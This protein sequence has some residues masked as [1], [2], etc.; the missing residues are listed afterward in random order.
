MS[1]GYCGDGVV[2]GRGL[3][4]CDS[5]GDPCCAL[6]CTF[7]QEGTLCASAPTPYCL[8]STCTGSNHSCPAPVCTGFC[9][10]FLTNG[11]EVCDYGPTGSANCTAFCAISSC[12]DGHINGGS[13]ETCE[14][15]EAGVDTALCNAIDCTASACGDGILNLAAGEVCDASTPGCSQCQCRPGFAP[16]MLCVECDAGFFA[17]ASA[18]C[19]ACPTP[20]RCLGGARCT[21]STTGEL[22]ASCAAGFFER[23]GEC[24]SC[25]DIPWMLVAQVAAV[26][27]AAYAGISLSQLLSSSMAARL[28]FMVNLIQL[29]SI[30]VMVPEFNWPAWFLNSVAR[31]FALLLRLEGSA[32]CLTPAWVTW[33]VETV[34]VFA[35]LFVGVAAAL[36]LLRVNSMRVARAKNVPSVLLEVLMRRMKRSAAARKNLLLVVGLVFMPLTRRAMASFGCVETPS[37]RYLAA[38]VDVVCMSSMHVAAM[39]ASAAV[40]L[41]VSVGVPFFI[42]IGTLSLKRNGRLDSSFNTYGSLYDVYKDKH[43]YFEGVIFVRRLATTLAAALISQGFMVGLA[44]AGVLLAYLA[45]VLFVRPYRAY[46]SKVFGVRVR[47]LYTVIDILTMTVAMLWNALGAFSVLVADGGDTAVF[48]LAVLG[49]IILTLAALLAASSTSVSD[50]LAWVARNLRTS[51]RKNADPLSRI[52]A[53]MEGCFVKGGGGRTFEEGELV[54]GPRLRGSMNW[55]LAKYYRV[56]LNRLRGVRLSQCEAKMA[57]IKMKTRMDGAEELE[58]IMSALVPP[59][60]MTKSEVRRRVVKILDEVFVDGSGSGAKAAKLLGRGGASTVSK[61]AEQGDAAESKET[62]SR[63]LIYLDGKARR[64]RQLRAEIIETESFTGL[65][66]LAQLDSSIEALESARLSVDPSKRLSEFEKAIAEAFKSLARE[67]DELDKAIGQVASRRSGKAPGAIDADNVDSC[68]ALRHSEVKREL[69]LYAAALDSVARIEDT[70][71]AAACALD[72]FQCVLEQAGQPTLGADRVF[73]ALKRAATAARLGN[74]AVVQRGMDHFHEQVKTRVSCGEHV[75]MFEEAINDVEELPPMPFGPDSAEVF[76]PKLLEAIEER[77]RSRQASGTVDYLSYISELASRCIAE[78]Q[79]LSSSGDWLGAMTLA[80]FRLRMATAAM[81]D[82]YPRL[83]ALPGRVKMLVDPDSVA[84]VKRAFASSLRAR[85]ESTDALRSKSSSDFVRRPSRMGPNAALPRGSSPL[86]TPSPGGSPRAG[87]RKARPRAIAPPPSLGS[88]RSSAASRQ[89][90]LGSSSR[91][92]SLAESSPRGSPRSIGR[93][94][95]TTALRSPSS[96]AGRYATKA[97]PPPPPVAENDPPPPPPPENDDPPPPPPQ[98]EQRQ[99]RRQR[100][101]S[102]RARPRAD[103]S[104][105]GRRAAAPS[106]PR[107][108]GAPPSLPG[109]GNL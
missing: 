17:A 35:G 18:T 38:D 87:K 21:E 84:L 28:R 68:V 79:R 6:N 61:R 53:E 77:R 88:P 4:D 31:L 91:G 107:G 96:N 56:E 23:S 81:P 33:A 54:D 104:R 3:E 36:V 62:R 52:E 37:G 66:T 75:L 102:S 13:G 8:P 47:N 60:R 58:R 40:L 41:F 71:R 29:I 11:D 98:E 5:A 101:S 46:P 43:V 30:P 49:L 78:E 27:A 100:P 86:R 65:R 2:N 51:T 7:E 16:D 108:R 97:L 25:P 90:L 57:N 10:D 70:V 26:A 64:L 22:C 67:A 24:A 44:E 12:G 69:S 19:S 82:K 9:G 39:I 74:R 103:G 106:L 72:A 83:P 105:S 94:E 34:V 73:S 92:G 63:R 15:D 48:Q 55:A 1:D 45:V 76:G 50:T 20:A 93:T 89:D 32:A 85:T 14:V 99:P 109:S 80:F 42:V 59:R 95:S